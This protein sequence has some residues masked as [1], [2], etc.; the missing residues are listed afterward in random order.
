[1]VYSAILIA[2]VVLLLA[3]A[4]ERVSPLVKVPSVIVMVVLGLIA[5][6]L[7][8]FFGFKLEGLAVMVP[9]I[10]TIGLVLIVLEGAFD[11]NLRRDRLNVA[12]AAFAMAVAGFVLCVALFSMLA[13]YVLEF[14]LFQAMVLAIPFA[15]ISSAVAIPSSSFLPEQG[16]EFV[17]F[18]SSVSD[19]LGILV[20]YALL[21]SDGSLHGVLLGL[22]G[23]SALSLLLA[24][25]FSIGLVLVLMRL[26][27]HIRFVPLLAGLFGLYA[28]GTLLHLSPLI[29][30]LLFGLVLNNPGI[31]T[32]FRPLRGWMD[33]SYATTLGEFKVLVLELTFAVRGFFFILLGYWTDLSDLASIRAWLA[34][35]LILLLIFASRQALLKLARHD[36]ADSLKWIAP[37]GL[38]TVLLFLG[39]KDALQLP[40]YLNGTAVLVVLASTALV[41]VARL[42]SAADRPAAPPVDEGAV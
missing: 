20:F 37:R 19:I 7:F 30:V 15:V 12:A 36:L 16:R 35:V 4:I 14:S 41:M 26:E 6:P 32:R 18:E 22:V 10:G 25:F 5:K 27:G 8:S 38:I 34:A 2:S 39:A 40:S 1:M 3:F 21:N 17:V 33:A 24:V 13:M 28:A 31:I 42:R 23:G 29:M 9:V 11:I